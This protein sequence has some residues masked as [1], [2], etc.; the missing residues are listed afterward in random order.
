MKTSRKQDV[1]VTAHQV[2]QIAVASQTDPRTVKRVLAGKPTRQM[3]AAR[4]SIALKQA[5][6]R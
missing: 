1:R 5:G 2:R 6:L 4:V 3:T